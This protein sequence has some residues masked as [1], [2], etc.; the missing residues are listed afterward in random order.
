MNENDSKEILDVINLGLDPNL[1]NGGLYNAIMTLL[2][3]GIQKEKITEVV[4]LHFTTR[5]NSI[6]K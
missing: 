3:K 5:L 2:N 6:V 4:K 1:D